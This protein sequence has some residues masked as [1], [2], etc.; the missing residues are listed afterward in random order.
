[1]NTI[2]A[3]KQQIGQ[4]CANHKVKSLHAFGSVLTSTFHSQSDIDL[5]VSFDDMELA[6]Y[7]DNYYDLKFSLE[8]L[9]N[10]PV[11]LLEEQAIRNP[12]FKENVDQKKELVYG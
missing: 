9:F 12:Y 1:M 7:A 8:E 2:Q 4:L 5:I 11:D 6:E 10:R 3:Y